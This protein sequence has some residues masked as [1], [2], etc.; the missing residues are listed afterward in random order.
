MERLSTN[1]QRFSLVKS[2]IEESSDVKDDFFLSKLRKYVA[3]CEVIF[4]L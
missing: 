4:G 2:D 1:C 3:Y